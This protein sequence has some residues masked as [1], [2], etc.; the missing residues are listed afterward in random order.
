MA[1]A[2]LEQS[3]S[4]KV[5]VQSAGTQPADS[6]NPLVVIAMRERGI[7]LVG[8]RPKLL[9][10]EMVDQADRIITMGC[11]ESV[12][13]ACPVFVSPTED[14]ALEDPANK[15]FQ[16]IREIRDQIEFLVKN[17][18]ANLITR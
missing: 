18:L 13:E 1:A 7:D 6:V 10:R 4:E 5:A 15:S 16:E 11:S 12:Q 9:T 3:T 8:H 2:F 17:L 14:W